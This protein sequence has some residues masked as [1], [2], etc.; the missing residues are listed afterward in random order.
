MPVE[1]CAMTVLKLGSIV[2]GIYLALQGLNLLLPKAVK[3]RIDKAHYNAW[4]VV[5]QWKERLKSDWLFEP[6]FRIWFALAAIAISVS[7]AVL[8]VLLWFSEFQERG[9]YNL[10][11]YGVSIPIG[12]ALGWLIFVFI[13]KKGVAGPLLRAIGVFVVMATA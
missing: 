9:W 3:E 6:T 2:L 11:F 7:L 10:L 1:G 12:A 4:F 13:M 5:A 8:D